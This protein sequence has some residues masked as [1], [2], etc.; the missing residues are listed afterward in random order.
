MEQLILSK[1]SLQ[2]APNKVAIDLKC[3]LRSGPCPEQHI[4]SPAKNIGLCCQVSC[5]RPSRHECSS[6]VGRTTCKLA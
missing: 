3:A 2:P 6:H 4:V 1:L 5:A